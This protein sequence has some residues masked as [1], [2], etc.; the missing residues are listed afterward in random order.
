MKIFLCSHTKCLHDNASTYLKN[1]INSLSIS[2]DITRGV[3]EDTRL[4]AKAKESK[5]IQGQGQHFQGQNLLRPR[6]GMLEAKA[7]DQ[8]R[9]RKCSPKKSFSG[10]LKKC[11]RKFSARFPAL[12]NKILMIQKI[13]L[14]SSRGQCNFREL[15]ASRQR[16]RIS[17]CVLEDSTSGYNL[18]VND[19]NWLLQMATSLNFARSQFMFS[20]ASPKVLNLLPLSLH[21]IELFFLFQQCLRA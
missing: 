6:T 17:K 9:K 14:S 2:L 19:D 4:E 8:G 11:L 18:R 7:Q 21:E 3:V 12:S 16:P 1:L 5:K 20:H 15:E 13:V 10:D